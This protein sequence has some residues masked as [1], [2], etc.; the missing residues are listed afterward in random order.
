MVG[1][2]LRVSAHLPQTPEFSLP[3]VKWP[4]CHTPYLIVQIIFFEPVLRL[5]GP[6]ISKSWHW[7]AFKQTSII[8]LR[9][10]SF[11]IVTWLHSYISVSFLVPIGI[12][13][14]FENAMGCTVWRTILYLVIA[15]FGMTQNSEWNREAMNPILRGLFL[16]VISPYNICKNCFRLVFICIFDTTLHVS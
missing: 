14:S 10:Q 7:N 6:V 12:W 16:K 2:S 4:F 11:P 8:Q 13:V 3:P 5:C 15:L 9:P 1:K